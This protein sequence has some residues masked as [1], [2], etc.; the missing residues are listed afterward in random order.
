MLQVVTARPGNST[1]V[2]LTPY[3]EFRGSA[4]DWKPIEV[5]GTEDFVRPSNETGGDV[6][7]GEEDEEEYWEEVVDDNEEFWW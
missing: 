6:G 7:E 5:V 1:G 4:Y 3:S 2:V